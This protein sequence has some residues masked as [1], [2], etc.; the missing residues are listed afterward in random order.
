MHMILQYQ[1]LLKDKKIIKHQINGSKETIKRGEIY[2]K[3]Y[4]GMSK[5]ASICYDIGTIKPQEKKELRNMH[6][7]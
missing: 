6:I 5:D 4:I 7:S 2:D 3:D 1:H